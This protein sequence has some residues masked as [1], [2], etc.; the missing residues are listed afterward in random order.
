LLK[1]PPVDTTELDKHW[2]SL[3]QADGEKA[4]QAMQAFTARPKETLV[5]FK[6][7]LRPL[8]A[9]APERLTQ[10]LV[11]LQSNQY[12][13][14]QRAT[15]ELEQLDLQARLA[16]E[17]ALDAQP[18]VE[19]RRRIEALLKKLEPPFVTPDRLRS[20]RAVE[21]LERIGSMDARVFLETLAAG[22]RGGR[23]TEDAGAALERLSKRP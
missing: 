22:G 15:E 11:D 20:I 14:R 21:I 5:F 19:A 4:S 18:A 1:D 9:V 23:L 7:R 8:P 16:L 10:L 12:A 6:A 17:K 2:A 3:G 13:V